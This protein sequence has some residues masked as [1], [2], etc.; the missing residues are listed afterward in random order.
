MD[1]LDSLPG[2][3][4]EV[5]RSLHPFVKKRQ[6]V[7]EIRRILALHLT[8]HI[9]SDEARSIARPLSLL[10]TSS[11]FETIPHGFRGIRK[12]YLRCVRANINARTEN[13][14]IHREHHGAH[15]GHENQDSVSRRQGSSKDPNA[16]C[17]PIQSFL[18]LVTQRQKH[19]RLHIVQD[20]I[21]MLAE[22][23]AASPGHLDPKRVLKDVEALPKMPAEIIQASNLSQ[24]SGRAD[25]KG[26]VDQLE[27]SVLRA[28]LLLKREQKFL[29]KLKA[30]YDASSNSNGS[31]QEALGYTRNFLI[32]WI[33]DELAGAGETLPESEGIQ[34]L[35]TSGSK[36]KAFIDAQLIAIQKQY[37]RYTKARQSLVAVATDKLDI[38]IALSH[39]DSV[40][41]T[42]K[43]DRG[44]SAMSQVI[45]P[46]LEEMVTVSNEQKAMIQQKS[47]LT[48]TLAKQLKEAGQGLSRMADE[49]H[50]LPIHPL[51]TI[52]SQHKG[53]EAPVSFGDEISSHEKA[54]T[55]CRAQAWVF[56][57][58][59]AGNATK[60]LISDRLEEGDAIVADAQQTLLEL[61]NLLGNKN[62]V[63]NLDTGLAVSSKRENRKSGDIWAILD[64]NL[65]VNKDDMEG[66]D[67]A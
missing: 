62:K 15:T 6:E 43:N 53:L 59:A 34:D 66:H 37:A 33:E 31:R 58:E 12:E 17:P 55:S 38:A 61:H 13:A 19:D 64:G 9:S 21:D 23:P 67:M 3:V 65:G 25:L 28:K 60:G 11:G 50:L 46:Y 36:G 63:T 39:K 57:A 7:V 48:I 29:A 35:H 1:G 41:S 44:L 20:Y 2:A 45:H 40:I 56:A 5:Q 14:A 22:K 47:Y 51:P 4:K 10:E 32:N 30:E 8:S 26:L 52:T 16:A 49:S 24:G 54:D 42:S 27:K 18:D